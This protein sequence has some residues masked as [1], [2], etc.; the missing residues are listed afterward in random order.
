VA[1]AVGV[2][3]SSAPAQASPRAAGVQVALR[4]LGLYVGPID[5]QVGS[6]TAAAVRAAQVRARLPATGRIDARTC[7]SLG[8]LGRPPL[9]S[10]VLR[11][12]DFGLD[13]SE[14]QFLLTQHG[15]YV[16]ALDGYLGRQV[17]A[18]VRHY[19]RRAHMAVDGIVGPGTLAALRR[20]GAVSSPVAVSPAHQYY[21]VQPGDSLT[22]IAGHFGLTLGRLARANRLDPRH[23]LLIGQ[24]LTVPVA[25]RELTFTATPDQVRA[26]IDVW[27]T[28]L[29]VSPHLVRALAW[30]ESGFQPQVVSPVGARGVLQLLPVT[31]EFVQ[32]VLAGHAL[33]KTVDGDVEAGVLYLRHLLGQFDGNTRLALGAWYQGENAVRRFGLYKVTKPFIADV[34]ALATRM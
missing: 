5:G 22:A 12:G 34:L 31:R 6:Q 2:L 3:I 9:G 1:L 8:P 18:A 15:I 21:V 11:P 29:G 17:E 13:V 32:E 28:R 16:G 33:P 4:A 19:Q 25:V 10:R 23:V 24:R 14:L 20:A 26:S 7:R 30:M 27:S